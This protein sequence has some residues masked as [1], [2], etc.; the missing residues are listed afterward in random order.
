MTRVTVTRMHSI[1]LTRL[2]RVMAFPLYIHCHEPN[3]IRLAC[4]AQER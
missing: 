3:T 4:P 1:D 2:M